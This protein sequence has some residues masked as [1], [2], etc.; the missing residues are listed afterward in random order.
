MRTPGTPQDSSSAWAWSRR[1]L[2]F[3]LLLLPACKPAP[4]PDPERGFT[5]YD[6]AW[7]CGQRDRLTPLSRDWHRYEAKLATFTEVPDREAIFQSGYADGF[8]Q[9]PD[10]PVSDTILEYDRD[11]RRG[12]VDAWKGVPS[13]K[14]SSGYRDGHDGRPHQH[15][16]VY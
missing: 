13:T 8:E 14:T 16:R 7:R 2:L 1:S 11:F 10:E 5:L 12:R 6:I 15:G 9:H 3:W 4:T